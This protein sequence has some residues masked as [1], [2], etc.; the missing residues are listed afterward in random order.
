MTPYEHLLLLFIEKAYFILK[1][2]FIYN[3]KEVTEMNMNI[4]YHDGFVMTKN[5]R[6]IV[7]I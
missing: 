7:K 1:L 4:I 5:S 6:P 2:Q 3:R